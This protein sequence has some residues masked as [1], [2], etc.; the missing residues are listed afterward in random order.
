MSDG[1]APGQ[2]RADLVAAADR[3]ADVLPLFTD[4]TPEAAAWRAES[5][6]ERVD[7]GDV[8][9]ITDAGLCGRIDERARAWHVR[10]GYAEALGDYVVHA[11]RLGGHYAAVAGYSDENGIGLSVM[12]IL[13]PDLRVLDFAEL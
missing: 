2:G 1:A 12:L 4:T 6:I 3:L 9:V 13:D 10:A 8:E 5:G 11:L 7:A